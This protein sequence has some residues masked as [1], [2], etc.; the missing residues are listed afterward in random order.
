MKA[1]F[2]GNIT[3]DD[4]GTQY[5]V[6]GSGYYGGRALAEY[7]GVEVYVATH[8]ADDVR[9]LIRGV[10]DL[11][12][13]RVIELGVN[14]TPIFTISNGKA[15]GFRGLSPTI[16][17]EAVRLYTRMHR[18]D[19]V[20]V[21]PIMKEILEH[22]IIQIREFNSKVT[23]IDIQ[24]FVRECYDDSIRCLWKWNSEEALLT[25]DIVHGNIRE[26]CF[27]N[28]ETSI[29]KHIKDLSSAGG[30]SFL[31]SLD[32][33]GLYLVH[34][35][36]ALHIPSLSVKSVDDVGAGDILLAVTGYFRAMGMSMLESTTRGIS[37]AA[38]K[39]ENAYREW[40][41]KELLEMYSRE[42]LESIKSVDGV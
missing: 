27:T 19:A 9:G 1:L 37:A 14:G 25:V 11:Y 29:I 38:L 23:A 6:G 17:I 10:L 3:M 33:R 28:E 40:F 12:G 4:L 2:I 7:L 15:V 13:I 35:N 21:T 5:R 20:Y 31:V 30:T 32:D 41:N 36:E 42:L 22:Q 18:F 8:V 39:T 16:D 24:G 34:N 26:F